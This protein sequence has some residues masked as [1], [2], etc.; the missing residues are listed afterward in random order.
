M[1]TIVKTAFNE[2]KLLLPLGRL[3]TTKPLVFCT[4]GAKL[5]GVITCDPPSLSSPVASG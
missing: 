5:L 4:T 3:I 1:V 2:S